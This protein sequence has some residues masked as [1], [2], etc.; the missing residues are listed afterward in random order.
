MNSPRKDPYLCVVENH[1]AVACSVTLVRLKILLCSHHFMGAAFLYCETQSS[2]AIG[3]SLCVC[4]YS[5][6][7]FLLF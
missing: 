2:S 1:H 4:A 5:I 3:Q 6:M 7:Q